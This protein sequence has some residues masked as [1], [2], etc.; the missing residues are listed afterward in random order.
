MFINESQ[1]IIIYN[2]FQHFLGIQGSSINFKDGF[3][4][5]I[6]SFKSHSELREGQCSH[7]NRRLI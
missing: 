7:L 6:Y 2:Q 4:K 3:H 1:M 5:E